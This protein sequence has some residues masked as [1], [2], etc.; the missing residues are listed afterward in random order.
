MDVPGFWEDKG[1][2][3]YDGSVWFRKAF[4]LPKDYKGGGYRVNLGQVD[5]YNSAWVNG[6]P[7]GETFG[8][9]NYS[10]YTAPDSILR[11]KGNVVVVRVFDAGGKGGMYNMFWDWSWSGRWQYKTGR[12]IDASAFVRPRVVNADLFASPSILF[13]GCIAPITPLAVKGVI[14][15]Q[16]ESNA[17]RAE[18]YRQLFPAFIQDWRKQ[19]HQDL[20]F[21]FVQLANYMAEPSTPSSSEWAELRE[22]QASAL[23]LPK[24][25]MAVAIDIGDGS[26]IHPKNKQDVGKRL[27][28]AA[29]KAGYN[30]DTTH[31]SPLYT[32]METNNDSILIYFNDSV[33]TRDKYGYVRGFSIA[34][35]D[36]V[37][38]WAK[39]YI[40]N[41]VVVVF[42]ESVHRPIAVRYAWADNPG[43]LD[44]YNR[45]GMPAAPFRTDD[46]KRVTTGKQFSYKE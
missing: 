39:A 10:N 46:W 29:M 12:R 28:L 1:L 32:H 40:R 15:Y 41:N 17:S 31:T 45:Q 16:G 25:G 4:D 23:S 8:S 22:A 20:P 6:Y 36:S 11:Q 14:W 13:N 27:A 2:S 44:L 37:F 35:Q 38:H 21:L 3:G 19:F 9:L 24:T 18:E 34:G 7:I 26:D 43:P 33:L 42:N 5:D 30:M